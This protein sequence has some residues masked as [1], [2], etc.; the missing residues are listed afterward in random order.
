MSERRVRLAALVSHPI[1]YQAP[2]FRALAQEPGI[3]LEVL[4]CSKAGLQSHRDK[5]FGVAV[6]W[7]VPLLDG[8]AHRFVPN[9]SPRPNPS[10][11]LGVINPQ[12]YGAIRNGRFDVVWV[13]GWSLLSNW[14]GFASAFRSHVPVLLRGETNGLAEPAGCKGILKRNLLGRLFRKVDAVLAVGT[15][16]A[17]FYKAYGVPQDKI[18]VAPYTVDNDRFKAQAEVL[19]P[20]KR[21]LRREAG[22]PEEQPLIL[23]CGKLQPY[24]RPMDLLAAYAMLPPELGASLMFVVMPLN[25][26]QNAF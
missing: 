10:S 25:L 15:Q 22:L 20:Q 18:F 4:F 2:L 23:F 9:I 17:E 21:K 11:S 16:N 12:V 13:H 5:G 8:Y 7:D 6:Q 1:Q 3:D 26:R 14:F 19:V 24:K